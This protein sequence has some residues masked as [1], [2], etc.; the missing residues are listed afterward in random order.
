VGAT[1]TEG[2]VETTA[3]SRQAQPA[4]SAGAA[5]A[6]AVNGAAGLPATFGGARGAATTRVATSA[7]GDDERAFDSRATGQ[8]PAVTRLD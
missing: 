4:T 8:A 7:T 3:G 6:P 1:A 2:D 5:G